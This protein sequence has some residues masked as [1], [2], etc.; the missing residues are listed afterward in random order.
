MDIFDDKLSAQA[1]RSLDITELILEGKEVTSMQARTA[2]SLISGKLKSQAVKNGRVTQIISLVKLGIQ[3]A[4]KRERIAT[5][6]LMEIIPTAMLTSGE[7]AGKSPKA[8][9]K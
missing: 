4:E 2:T 6:A 8:L 9:A 1:L 5:T 3:D 7:V